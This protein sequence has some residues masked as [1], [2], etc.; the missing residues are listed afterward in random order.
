M[1]EDVIRFRDFLENQSVSFQKSIDFEK[2]INDEEYE[3]EEHQEEIVEKNGVY[4]GSNE[5]GE[6]NDI[7]IDDPDVE[8]R[9]TESDEYYKLY[10]GVNE[11]FV[12]DI[13]IDGVD[14]S[15]VTPRL[16]IETEKISI[17]Y[18]GFLENGKC[19]IPVNNLEILQEG[20]IGKIKLEIVAENSLFTPWEDNYKIYKK[21]KTFIK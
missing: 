8:S 14:I 10:Q 7:S 4:V 21:I 12:C 19:K 1:N 11:N 3:S 2:L 9:P 13:H 20:Q 18:K 16:I 15:K 6:S 17:M 5:K